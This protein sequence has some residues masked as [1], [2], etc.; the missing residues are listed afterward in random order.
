MYR[1]ILLKTELLYNSVRLYG[2]TFKRT[3]F[4]LLNRFDITCALT[5]DTLYVGS[6]LSVLEREPP[7]IFSSSGTWDSSLLMKNGLT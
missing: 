7:L 2:D 3:G 6:P 5:E 1:A 4:C